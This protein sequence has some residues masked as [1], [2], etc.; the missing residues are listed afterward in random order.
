MDYSD[1]IEHPARHDCFLW[2]REEKMSA[3]L[4]SATRARTKTPKTVAVDY[5]LCHSCG[6][7]VAVCPADALF[8]NDTRLEVKDAC[9]GCERCAKICPVRA[10]TV[11]ERVMP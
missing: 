5:D 1:K 8:L 3:G 10:L 11:V 7:C 4:P 2:M 9:T 6:A